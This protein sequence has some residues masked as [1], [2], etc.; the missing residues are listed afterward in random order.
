MT[1]STLSIMIMA[2]LGSATISHATTMTFSDNTFADA[3]W[4][5]TGIGSGLLGFSAGKVSTGGNPGA[6]RQNTLTFNNGLVYVVNLNPGFVYTPSTLPII[7]LTGSYDVIRTGPIAVGIRLA[8]LQNGSYYISTTGTTSAENPTWTSGQFFLTS[9]T[10]FSLISGSGPLVPDFSANAAPLELGYASA[11]FDTAPGTTLT[12]QSGIDNLSITVTSGTIG[13]I[14][15]PKSVSLF[16][17][18]IALMAALKLRHV[19]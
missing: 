13:G 1:K 7:Q 4:T 3:D 17:A 12:S 5:A 9:A 10:S 8:L 2:T 18:G 15:E 16:T 11:N 6:F 14:P 19:A